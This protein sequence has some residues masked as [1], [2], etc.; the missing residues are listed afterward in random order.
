MVTLAYNEDAQ[1]LL[2][3]LS[4]LHETLGPTEL[5]AMWFDDHYFPGM[6][7]PYGYSVEVW[8]RGQA[9]WRECFTSDER[10][11][12]EKFHCAFKS[13]L[14][15]GLSEE[16]GTWRSDEGWLRVSAA[17]TRALDELS[18]MRSNT[19]LERTRDG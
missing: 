8:E 13:E 3:H 4:G 2:T 18:Q 9:E 15:R 14:E 5:I 1:S 7:K 12:L 11:V 17:A 6:E 10:A 16:W 19:S